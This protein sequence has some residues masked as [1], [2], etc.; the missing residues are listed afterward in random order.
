M[1]LPS[2]KIALVRF[3]DPRVFVPLF[4]ALDNHARCSYFGDIDEWHGLLDGK[5]F[6][7]SHHA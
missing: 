7:V 2:G 6:Q 5:R 4:N 3:W 1:K